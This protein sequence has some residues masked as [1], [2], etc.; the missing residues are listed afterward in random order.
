MSAEERAERIFDAL[1][2]VFARTGLEGA[3]MDAIAAEA[4]MSKR[5]LYGLFAD[6]EQLLGAYMVRIRG[7][8]VHELQPQDRDLPLEDR[9]RRLLAPCPRRSRSGLP[10]AVLRLALSG[11]ETE[12]DPG[13]ARA[14][15]T[16]LRRQDRRLIR[17]ELDRAVADG[18]ARIPD[19]DAAAAILEG[20]IRPSIAD[21]LLEPAATP[22]RDALHARF[23]TG[24]AM[25]LAAVQP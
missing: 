14:R 22:D 13:S 18:E 24:L 15:L 25:F 23:E 16:R 21:A 10:A 2:S 12:T 11:T 3:T 5:T 7:Q 19:T 20:M 9:L 1:D 8:F 4:G 6:R 17:A